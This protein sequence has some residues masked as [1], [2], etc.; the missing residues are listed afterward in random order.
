MKKLLLS[1]AAFFVAS[2]TP[3]AASAQEIRGD[4]IA[5]EKKI[6]LCIGCHG[7]VGYHASFPESHKVP[8]ISGQSA[9]YI[10]SALQAYKKG[11]R[12]HPSMRGVADGLTE[13]DIADL[14]A[15]YS[16]H[17]VDTNQAPLA[18]ASGGSAQAMELVTK[19]GCVSCHGD[20]FSKPVDP[21]YPKIAGQHAD[22][23]FVAL[24]SYKTSKGDLIGR[25][26]AIMGGIAKQFSNEELKVLADYVGSL[27]GDL[28]TIQQPRFR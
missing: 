18:K 12:K 19:G 26:N 6:A 17:G 8:K 1:L 28:K 27:P 22:Y 7:I 11:A 5:G 13:Q 24:K 2:A 15:F 9:K 14:A 23:L 16:G 25:D 20:N 3:L 4:A 10:A 21:S